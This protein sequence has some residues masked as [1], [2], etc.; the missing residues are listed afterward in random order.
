M[1]DQTVL[2]TNRYKLASLIQDGYDSISATQDT[3]LSLADVV[4]YVLNEVSPEDFRDL[5]EVAL[6]DSVDSYFHPTTPDNTEGLS[7]LLESLGVSV[8]DDLLK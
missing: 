7:A 6:Y 4:E 8:P 1:T 5:L 2:L 3:P